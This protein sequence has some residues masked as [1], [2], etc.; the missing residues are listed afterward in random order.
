MSL[1]DERTRAWIYRVLTAIV[2]L[3][4]AQGAIEGQTASLWLALAG[5]VL[6]TGLASLNTS[7][8]GRDV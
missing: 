6:G 3:L 5:A 2:P 8:K 7:T 1:K 4:I